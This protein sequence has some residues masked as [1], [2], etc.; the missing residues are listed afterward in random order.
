MKATKRF[1]SAIMAMA[2]VC[3]TVVTVSADG[4]GDTNTNNGNVSPTDAGWSGT[5]TGEGES[6]GNINMDEFRIVL[7]TTQINYTVDS[8]GLIKKSTANGS[9]KRDKKTTVVYSTKDTFVNGTKEITDAKATP[10]TNDDP[11]KCNY[12]KEDGFVFFSTTDTKGNTKMASYFDITI[13]NKSSFGVDITP[14]LNYEPA[15]ENAINATKYSNTA[16]SKGLAFNL[17]Q[18]TDEMNEA[19]TKATGRKIYTG[20]SA[21]SKISVGDA[22]VAWETVYKDN[23]YKYDF[24]DK[25]YTAAAKTLKNKCYFTLEG[26]A[27]NDIEATGKPGTV[28]IVWTFAKTPATP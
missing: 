9:A 20:L 4:E 17:Y 3:G 11:K 21:T 2:M 18:V 5:M 25:K 28:S 23:A 24:S 22:N 14:V 10:V 8:Q 12:V 16:A 19:G 26:V 13:E 1:L 6:E 27:A 15:A 7:P